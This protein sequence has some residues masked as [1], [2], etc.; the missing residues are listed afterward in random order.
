MPLIL[1]LLGVAA[2]GAAVLAN[3][4]Q[5]TNPTATS[6]NGQN[7]NLSGL[8]VSHN[9]GS[10]DWA[11]VSQAGFSFAFIKATEGLTFTDPMY[12]TN[13]SVAIQNGLRAYPYH[14]F[15]P[16]DDGA[17]QAGCFLAVIGSYRG[18]VAVDLE[19]TDTP[20]WG[21][22]QAG[23]ADRLQ[24]F[25]NTLV[26]AGLSPVIYTTQSFIEQFLPTSSWLGL[27]PLWIA[28]WS[29]T[30]PDESQLPPF[31]SVATYWQNTNVGN[32]AGISGPVD[33][34]VASGA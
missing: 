2:I 23:A 30:P 1:L 10:I 3:K 8:D 34:D 13:I 28:H 6:G 29:N 24:L 31:W 5:L 20:I 12:A 15:H 4:S 11:Q 18:I 26:K 32:V 7:F 17:A 21:P 22:A 33:L 19:E 27:Y 25:L 16:E 9:N 14:F